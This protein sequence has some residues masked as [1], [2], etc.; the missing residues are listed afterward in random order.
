MFEWAAESQIAFD[1]LKEF[2]ATLHLLK[3]PEMG[4]PLIVYL[5]VGEESISL[6]L[7]RED[8]KEQ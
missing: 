7:V 2:L 6:V 3:Q 8:G 1:Q 4:Y 5:A